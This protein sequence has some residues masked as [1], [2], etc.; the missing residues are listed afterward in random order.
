[1]VE[2][3]GARRL[4]RSASCKAFGESRRPADLVGT[5]VLLGGAGRSHA[6][7]PERRRPSGAEKRC[8]RARGAGDALQLAPDPAGG[9]LDFMLGYAAGMQRAHAQALVQVK[10]T[11][12]IEMGVL[13]C[14]QEQVRLQDRLAKMERGLA[15]SVG[16]MN[17]SLRYHAER[18]AASERTAADH[19]RRLDRSSMRI[20]ALEGR[21]LLATVM[22]SAQCAW[23]AARRFHLALSDWPLT[24]EQRLCLLFGAVWL[25]LRIG[26]MVG[27]EGRL[28]RRAAITLRRAGR[29]SWLLFIVSSHRASRRALGRA[30]AL[31]AAGT[32]SADVS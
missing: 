19:R 18:L 6:V 12:A 27:A 5:S 1:M 4:E 21:T 3:G 16:Y 31:L 10:K 20:E 25:V 8:D 14:Q 9:T 11:G 28:T 23:D 22:R 17:C 30:L 29:C 15:C 24:N 7:S 13:V 32:R 2:G 26:T